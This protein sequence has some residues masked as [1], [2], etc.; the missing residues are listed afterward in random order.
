MH[1]M[2]KMKNHPHLKPWSFLNSKESKPSELCIYRP[3]FI[4]CFNSQ[5]TFTV[6]TH[7]LDYVISEALRIQKL[8]SLNSTT[9]KGTLVTQWTPDE[10]ESLLAQNL[11]SLFIYKKDSNILGYLVASHIDL[12]LKEVP[13]T[14]TAETIMPLREDSIYIYQIATHPTHC[15]HGVASTLLN[16]L[17][18]HSGKQHHFCDIM[19]DP[20]CNETSLQFFA[21]HDYKHHGNYQSLNY[22][23]FGA[24]H[25]RILHR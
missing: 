21:R 4:E 3:E 17:H 24:A 18:L 12:L 9:Q 16:Y 8:N 11:S 22:R 20:N 10:L 25:W 7:Y 15:R 2:A 19:I 5:S 6:N 1:S 14:A 13:D 23:N